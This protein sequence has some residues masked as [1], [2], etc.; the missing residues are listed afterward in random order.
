MDEIIRIDASDN[1][2]REV[3]ELLIYRLRE[4]MQETARF[5]RQH[6]RRKHKDLDVEIKMIQMDRV[7]TK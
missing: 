6:I 1:A 7:E 3:R 2:I 5:G 4:F